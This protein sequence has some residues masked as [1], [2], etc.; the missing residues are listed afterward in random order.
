[1]TV[2]L[3]PMRSPAVATRPVVVV[4]FPG[5]Q[6]LDV[7]GPVEVLSMANR[8]LDRWGSPAAARYDVRLVAPTTGPVSTSSGLTLMVGDR[9]SSVRGRLDT[10]L[11]AGGE[12]VAR[13]LDDER[14]VA[15]VARLAG[16]SRRVTSV[17][18]GAFVL[19]AAGLLDGRR[20]TTHWSACDRL[21]AAHPAIDVDP[22][23]IFVTD[24]PVVTS[25]GVTAGIDL[26]LALVEADHGR[27]L[28][29]AVARQL[30]VFLKRPGGQSQFSAHLRTE[31][32]ERHGLAE[33]QRSPST[34]STPTC[35]SSAWLSG[36]P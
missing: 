5:V 6:S 18:T 17:C 1:M 16:R 14:S 31:L 25:A 33:V 4:V 24:G 3:A 19:A 30:V 29:L 8:F 7:T 21:A 12:G 2:M 11:V 34:T 32:T 27:P 15:T 28:A 22:E 10:L 20:A 13:F 36:R 23:A 35:G 9:L 26:C